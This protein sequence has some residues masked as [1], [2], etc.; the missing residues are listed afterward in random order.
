MKYCFIILLVCAL[1][2]ACTSRKDEGYYYYRE[3]GVLE[4]EFDLLLA[5]QMDYETEVPYEDQIKNTKTK[6][7]D[8]VKVAKP[9]K[10]P[11]VKK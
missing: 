10:K 1:F 7:K 4:E 9:Q 5:P 6:S 2:C 8:A 11:T 3:N